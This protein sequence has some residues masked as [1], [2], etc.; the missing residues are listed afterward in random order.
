MTSW[1]K[2]IVLYP[3]RQKSSA[4]YVYIWPKNCHSNRGWLII[5]FAVGG[6]P[7]VEKYTA[8]IDD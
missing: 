4:I 6:C 5:Y 1:I 2:R 8:S 3:L 7:L